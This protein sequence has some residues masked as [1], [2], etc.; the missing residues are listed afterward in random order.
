MER[1]LPAVPSRGSGPSGSAAADGVDRCRSDLCRA[2]QQFAGRGTFTWT[3]GPRTAALQ[4]V[5]AATGLPE[6]TRGAGNRRNPQQSDGVGGGPH[7]RGARDGVILCSRDA[8]VSLQKA[9]TVMGLPDEALLRLPVDASGGL[10]LA[11]LEQTLRDLRHAG[12]RCLAVVATAGTTVRGAVDPL[13]EI[14]R[15][16]RREEV[17]LHVDAAIGGVFA[18]WEPLAP[19]LEGSSRRTRSRQSA[20]AAGGSAKP[21]PCWLLRDRSHPASAFATGLPYMESPLW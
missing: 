2:E 17:W 3:V 18:L 9:A 10:S 15:I 7:L 6:Q 19:L 1:R 5:R 8:H 4:M 14:A 13:D 21:R 11:G 12:R 16:C 20:E